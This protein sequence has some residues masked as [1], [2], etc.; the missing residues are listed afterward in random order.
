LVDAAAPQQTAYCLC[1]SLYQHADGNQA[2]A[3]VWVEP[4]LLTGRFGKGLRRTAPDGSGGG[5]H[6]IQSRPA[7]M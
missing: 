3:L 6:A 4:N 7:P 1:P 2:K 5:I